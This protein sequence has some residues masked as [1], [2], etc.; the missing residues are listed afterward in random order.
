MRGELVG[1]GVDVVDLNRAKRFVRSHGSRLK[2]F[3]LPHEFRAQRKS[4]SPA[5]SFAILFAAKEATSKSL[6]VS[7]THPKA[8]RDFRVSTTGRRLGV[9]LDRRL[10][11]TGKS[12]IKAVTFEVP[13]SVGVMALHFKKN[14]K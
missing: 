2:S 1:L 9:K 8:F 10:N 12:K 13:G 3:L 4:S 5:R 6:N 11:R 14:S 7:V